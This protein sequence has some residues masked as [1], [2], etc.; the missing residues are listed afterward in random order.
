[1]KEQLLTIMENSKNYTVAVASVMPDSN[2]VF[3]P[4]GTVWAF[5]EL[6]HHIAYGI[7]WWED[8]YIKG[9]KTEWTP[10]VAKRHKKDIL[11]YL[12]EAYT[13]LGKTISTIKLSE[14]AVKGFHATMDHITHHRGQAVL[15]LRCNG[16]TPPEYVY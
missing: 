11:A 12:D 14:D 16:L 8:N 6:L 2:Y 9:A 1:M 15:Y 13:E 5:G 3:K 7:H 4:V 10:P